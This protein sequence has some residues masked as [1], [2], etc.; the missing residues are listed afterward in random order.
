M[1]PFRDLTPMGDIKGGAR[2]SGFNRPSGNNAPTERDLDVTLKEYIDVKFEALNHSILAA[3]IEM[4]RRMNDANN[5]RGEVLEDRSQYLKLDRFESILGEWSNWRS[6]FDNR[7]T[8]IE[9]RSVTW[10]GAL[11]VFFVLIQVII[12]WLSHKA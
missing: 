10:T 7:L 6:R 11:G 5:L 8:I 9:T 2:N 3:K 1:K 4:D 12:Y